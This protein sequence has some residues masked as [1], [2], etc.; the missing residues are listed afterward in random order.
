MISTY[1]TEKKC[2]QCFFQTEKLF[3]CRCDRLRCIECFYSSCHIN[4]YDAVCKHCHPKEEYHQRAYGHID[5]LRCI[6]RLGCSGP[7]H[8]CYVDVS[9]K[10]AVIPLCRK[11]RVLHFPPRSPTD[12]RME[13]KACKESGCTSLATFFLEYC[14]EHSWHER[15]SRIVFQAPKDVEEAYHVW[16]V[17][18]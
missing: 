12:S 6:M 2:H 7:V 5:I 11:H 18:L 17:K 4:F 8:P 10:E 16:K 1:A 3:I 13:L 15:D 9:S 14:R